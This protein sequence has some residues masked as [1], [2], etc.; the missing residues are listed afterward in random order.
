MRACPQPEKREQGWDEREGGEDGWVA[1]SVVVPDWLLFIT[2]NVPLLA[3]QTAIAT[4][5]MRSTSSDRVLRVLG[6][7]GVCAH[8]RTCVR[9]VA[10]CRL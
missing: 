8:V 10:G 5:F 1:G 9:A 7:H 6:A 3:C 4:S 2:A